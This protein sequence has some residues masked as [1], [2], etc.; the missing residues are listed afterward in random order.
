MSLA[1]LT[2]SSRNWDIDLARSMGSGRNKTIASCYVSG[3]DLP[4]PLHHAIARVG[5]IGK[6]EGNDPEERFGFAE[7]FIGRT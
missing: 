7:N 6:C 4:K 3:F 1:W 5:T 2:G